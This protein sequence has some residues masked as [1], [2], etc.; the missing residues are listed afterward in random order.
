MQTEPVAD[1]AWLWVGLS[2]AHRVG[3]CSVEVEPIVLRLTAGYRVAWG[4]S[5]G[6]ARG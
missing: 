5:N 2:D 4:Y 1:A 6:P 3:I